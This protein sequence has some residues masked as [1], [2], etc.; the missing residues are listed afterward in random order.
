MIL[1]A[2]IWSLIVGGL[3][4]VIASFGAI[5]AP[6]AEW[7][8]A[9][10]D[11]GVWLSP[12]LS[13]LGSLGWF[14]AVLIWI[15]GLIVIGIGRSLFSWGRRRYDDYRYQ[16]RGRWRDDRA[17]EGSGGGYGREGWAGDDDEYRYRRRKKRWKRRDDDDDDD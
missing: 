17:W 2:L 9:N 1:L 16:D 4:W 14:A 6:S 10:P 8:A 3:Y 12:A 11:I 15:V 13:L 7:L 5:L